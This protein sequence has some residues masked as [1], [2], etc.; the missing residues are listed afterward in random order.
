[1]KKLMLVAFLLSILVSDI[2]SQACIPEW[3]QPGSGV[4][5]DT[6]IN[7]PATEVNTPYDFTVQFKVPKTDSSVIVTGVDVDHVELTGIAGL[8]AIPS[9]VPFTYTCNPSSCSFKGDS[10]GCVKIQGTPTTVGLY[11]LTIEAKVFISSFIF[12]EVDFSGYYIEV[13]NST[14]IPSVNKNKFD[15]SQ[16][17]PNPVYSTTSILVNLLSPATIEVKVFNVVGN[18]IFNTTVSGRPG[19]NTITLDASKFSSGIY[20]YTVGDGNHFLTKTL[21]VE[22]R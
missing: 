13:K 9:S 20:F 14:G 6:V 19:I 18:K 15:V 10:V 5:P 8:D 22:K 17:S 3:T 4:Y 2:F 11:P 7:L 21:V 1:M 12:Q 16:N